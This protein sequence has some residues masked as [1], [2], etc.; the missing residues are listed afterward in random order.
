MFREIVRS[1]R[2]VTGLA[3]LGIAFM[4]V[5]IRDGVRNFDNPARKRAVY[6]ASGSSTDPGAARTRLETEINRKI[7]RIISLIDEIAD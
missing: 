5:F 3:L 6:A 4:A 7:D 1:R 2:F